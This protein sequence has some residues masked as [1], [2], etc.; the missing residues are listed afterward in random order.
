[1]IPF[2]LAVIPMLPGMIKA[3]FDIADEV[4]VA[5]G[6]VPQAQRAELDAKWDEIEADVDS[7]R[8]DYAS[9]KAGG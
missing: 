3:G 2:L 5:I 6:E 4:K 7:A 9:A 1:M 8:A